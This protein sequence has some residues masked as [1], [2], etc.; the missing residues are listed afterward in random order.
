MLMDKIQWWKQKIG[1]RIEQLGRTKSF[2]RGWFQ[3]HNLFDQPKWTFISV[4]EN[5]CDSLKIFFSLSG[6]ETKRYIC[7]WRI[8]GS[9]LLTIFNALVVM[10][11]PGGAIIIPLFAYH[12]MHIGGQA[13]KVKIKIRQPYKYSTSTTT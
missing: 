3:Q 5:L 8:L 1:I 4:Q 10:L 12:Q 2:H 13:K 7:G 11:G 9:I 6:R